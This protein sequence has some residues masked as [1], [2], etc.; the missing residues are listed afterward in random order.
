MPETVWSQKLKELTN[1]FRQQN[2]ATLA[3]MESQRLTKKQ[4]DSD[5][6]STAL[7]AADDAMRKRGEMAL[8][9]AQ[10]QYDAMYSQMT[11]TNTTYTGSGSA[12]LN[13]VKGKGVSLGK[14]GLTTSPSQMTTAHAAGKSFQVNKQYQNR[15]VGFVTD[16]TKMGY[17]ISS[18]GGYNVRN[19]A[20]T[21]Q[22][23]L[24][25]YGAAIDINPGPNARGGVGNLPPH[26]AELAARYGLVWGGN[27]K[28]S[29]PMHFEVAGLMNPIKLSK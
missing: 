3:D 27:W 29:D 21:G 8:A 23:S 12:A 7:Q 16:L 18:I 1:A 15:F 22:K 2:Y 13:G 20:G 14:S 17:N 26:I 11:S 5:N 25:S 10:S 24:H 19:I 4:S 28:Y 9:R 6:T